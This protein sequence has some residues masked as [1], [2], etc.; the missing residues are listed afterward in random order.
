MHHKL[1][2]TGVQTHEHQIMHMAKHFMSLRRF[3]QR[4]ADART[5]GTGLYLISRQSVRNRT[6]LTT[7][8]NV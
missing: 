4:T 5:V 6:N 1:D 2:L 3:L 7:D 8:N